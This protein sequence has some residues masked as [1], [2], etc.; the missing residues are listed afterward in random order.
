[1]SA[2]EVIAASVSPL[3]PPPND[4]EKNYSQDLRPCLYISRSVFPRNSKMFGP[5]HLYARKIAPIFSDNIPGYDES[6]LK[7]A[8]FSPDECVVAPQPYG[9]FRSYVQVRRCLAK[10]GKPKQR[11]ENMTSVLPYCPLHTRQLLNL[12]VR[13]STIPN[14]G[15]GLF[16][17]SSHFDADSDQKE[18][19]VVFYNGQLIHYFQGEILE[20]KA[21]RDRYG[22]A[23]DASDKK[24]FTPYAARLPCGKIVDAILVRGI[25][26]CANDV[27]DLS[28]TNVSPGSDC[29]PSYLPCYASKTIYHG[30]ELFISY[31]E[32]WWGSFPFH[33]NSVQQ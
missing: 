16:A 13:A 22:A 6:E 30:D 14:A 18:R 3:D 8:A 28:K 23:F 12:E 29:R 2:T 17:Y 7:E 9:Y 32:A 27:R 15:N 4:Q 20:Y 1:M 31:G 21:Y 5:S 26:A 25:M 19:P 10:S 33:G 11:C 24:W